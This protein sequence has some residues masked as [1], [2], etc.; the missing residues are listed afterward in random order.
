MGKFTFINSVFLI[1]I[2]FTDVLFLLGKFCF[3][4]FMPIM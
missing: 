4:R 3:S 1:D 2:G